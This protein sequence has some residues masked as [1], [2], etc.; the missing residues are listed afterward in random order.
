MGPREGHEGFA[1]PG[2]HPPRR[3][4]PVSE[5]TSCKALVCALSE[6]QCSGRY[7]GPS[8]PSGKTSKK[9]HAL[10]LLGLVGRFMCLGKRE[11]SVAE[12]LTVKWGCPSSHPG[13]SNL[14]PGSA[15][16]PG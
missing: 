1:H 3:V 10:L 2:R 6:G 15:Y 16:N 14:A 4:L 9:H 5:E 7:G 8:G 11:N 12:I 13:S